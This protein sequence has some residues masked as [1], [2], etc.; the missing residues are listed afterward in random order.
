VGQQ[1]ADVPGSTWLWAGGAVLLSSLL[2]KPADDWARNNQGG[3]WRNVGAASNAVPY[4]LA[5]GTGL[6]FTGIAGEGAQD[7]ATTAIKAAA[8]TLGANAVTRLAAGRARPSQELGNTSFSGFNRDALDSGFASNHVALAFALATPFARQYRQPWLYAL[9]GASAIGRVQERDHWL[10]DTIAGA[11]MGYAFGS[12]LSNQPPSDT[13]MRL[14]VTPNSVT[15]Q[16][17]L[18]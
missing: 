13:A 3:N 12:F 10:S 9:A 16:W 18:K 15:A 1:L 14:S 5:L 11:F 17:P 7:T 6:L 2:D 4:A 8:Y